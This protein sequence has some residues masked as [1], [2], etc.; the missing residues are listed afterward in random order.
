V[1]CHHDSLLPGLMRT[2]IQLISI[3]LLSSA[4]CHACDDVIV[5]NI[6]TVMQEFDPASINLQSFLDT[7]SGSSECSTILFNDGIKQV[8]LD[9]VLRLKRLVSNVA[10]GQ[11]AAVARKVYKYIRISVRATEFNPNNTV[12]LDMCMLSSA[13]Y[14]RPL[15][16]MLRA[17]GEFD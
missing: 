13:D 7:F 6:A 4:V 8:S 2:N 14:L 1:N 15:L 9:T 17:L 11:R 5:D 12:G 16:S 3:S 10:L